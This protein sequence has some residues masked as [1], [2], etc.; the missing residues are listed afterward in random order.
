[1]LSELQINDLQ[2]KRLEKQDV[3]LSAQLGK[4]FQ[5]VFDTKYREPGEAYL[6]KLLESPGFIVYVALYKSEMAGGLTAYELPMVSRESTEVFIYDLAVRPE[7]QRRGIGSKL[8]SGLGEYCSENSIS[9]IFVLASE[10]D[11]HAVKFY[12]ANGGKM[13]KTDLFIFQV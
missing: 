2:I 11:E 1:M 13:E 7:F 4:L 12:L 6:S 5:E 3:S 9:E 10:E 8:L